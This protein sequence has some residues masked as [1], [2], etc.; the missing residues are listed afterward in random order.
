VRGDS[1]DIDVPAKEISVNDSEQPAVA[2][3]GLSA[4]RFAGALRLHETPPM[5]QRKAF[6]LVELLVVITI[7]GILIA[8]LLPAVQA[9][10]ESARRLQCSNNLKQLGLAAQ[11]HVA[12]HGHFPTGGWGFRWVL[13]PDGGFGLN[14][15]GGW[16]GNLLPYLEQEALHRRASGGTPAEKKTAAE[17]LVRTPLAMMNCPSRRPAQLYPHRP[18]TAMSNRPNN[19]GVEGVRTAKLGDV[20]KA[21]YAAN[22]GSVLT[23]CQAGPGAIAGAESYHWRKPGKFTG[24]VYERSMCRP[25]QIHDGTSNTY[26]FGEKY[27]DPDDYTGWNGVGDA[28]PMYIGCDPDVLRYGNHSLPL[29]RDRP[30]HSASRIFGGPH[31]SGCQFAFCDGSV[32][33]VAWSVELEV[34]RQ[35]SHRKDGEAIDA[36]AF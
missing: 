2:A 32:R 17:Q 19:P 7:I 27:L 34:H 5:S 14:Q 12:A 25:A 16:V 23:H 28:Q 13:E 29:L 31:V 15:P 3:R 22:A 4:G 10:R 21:D 20:A 36:A 9:A 18:N 30:G 24:V 33:Q 8:L 1:L 6:T 35:L 26:L 11:Q